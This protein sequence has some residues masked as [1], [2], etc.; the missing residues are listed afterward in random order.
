MLKYPTHIYKN[1][2]YIFA[3]FSHDINF[4]VLVM[5]NTTGVKEIRQAIHHG[6]Y[7]L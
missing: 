4:P 3:I 7:Q 5:T 6:E 1:Y 2:I